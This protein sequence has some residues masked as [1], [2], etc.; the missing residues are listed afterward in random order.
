MK[1]IESSSR[2]TTA[3]FSPYDNI[4]VEGLLFIR[5]WA[6]EPF[7]IFRPPAAPGTRLLLM[8][9]LQSTSLRLEKVTESISL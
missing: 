5:P 8:L 9:F 7:F 2:I 6:L 1:T 4:N 3:S